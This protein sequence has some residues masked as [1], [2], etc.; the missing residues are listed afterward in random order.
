MKI[1][2]IGL[3]VMGLP[4]AKHIANHS[5]DLMPYNRGE[6]RRMQWQQLVPQI[7]C[8]TDLISVLPRV[9]VVISC[10]GNDDDLRQLA[11]GDDGI[12][13]LCQPDVIW[14]D[15][16]TCSLEVTTEMYQ[17]CLQKK[18]HFIDA[19]VSGGQSGAEQ[20]KLSIMVGGDIDPVKKVKPVMDCYAKQVTH[21]GHSGAGQLTKMVNQ[22]CLA[23]LIQSLAEGL[24]FAQEQNL[25]IDKVLS[26]IGH[27]AAQSW[28]MDNRAKTM[29]DNLY[30]F[31]FAVDLMRKDLGICL[32][33]ARKSH[34]SL[35][36]TALVDQFYSDIQKMGYGH[37]DTSSL[38]LRLS[39]D[40]SPTKPK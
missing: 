17:A 29:A 32:E 34:C 2:F 16:S 26:A 22:I 5:Y 21:I 11:Y 35:P 27:G 37:F 1:G 31:G 25:D 36:V 28:Q 30:D 19:P 4:M 7:P 23:G 24:N 14:V 12:L 38:K 6:T 15:H 8:Q 18:M 3:G 33:Q 39:P 9:D 13:S 40:Y 20:G 10:V